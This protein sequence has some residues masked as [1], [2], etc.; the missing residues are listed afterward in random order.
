MP[1]TVLTKSGHRPISA[2]ADEI[3]E[4]WLDR[5]GYPNIHWSALPYLKVMHDL[6]DISDN[7]GYDSAR[8]VI[9]YF[10]SNASQY[11]G[12]DARR[13]KTELRKML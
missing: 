12:E 13:I 1:E 5:H 2:I 7:Y 3:C 11:R 9:R 10:L 4:T 6:N 8:S